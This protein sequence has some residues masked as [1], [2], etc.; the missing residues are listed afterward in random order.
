MSSSYTSKLWLALALFVQAVFAPQLTI[1]GALP[2][3]ATIVVVLY[4]LRVGAR[5][6]LLLG[7]MAGVVT[8]VLAGTGGAWTVAYLAIA[9]GSGAV[10]ARFFGDGVVMPSVLVAFAVL[11][12]NAIFWI[13]MTAEGF[14]RGYGTSHL[15]VA[16]EQAFYT[17]LVAAVAQLLRARFFADGD[18]RVG[19]YA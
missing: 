2:S 9:A 11:V 7:A 8:D 13:V 6:A 18:E 3:L 16:L 1:H 14:P 4:A 17:A 19:R 10:R 5:G 12:R 15:H